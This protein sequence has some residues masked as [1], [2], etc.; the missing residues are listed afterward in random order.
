MLQSGTEIQFPS[1]TTLVLLSILNYSAWLVLKRIK[2]KA[3]QK[4]GR[5]VLAI[6]I[7]SAVLMLSSC[8]VIDFLDGK[9]LQGSRDYGQTGGGGY[10]GGG[11]GSGGGGGSRG[12]HSH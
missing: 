1:G 3:G 9:H 8:A 10:R 2:I 7:S 12:G 4:I 6:L 11:T 5:A